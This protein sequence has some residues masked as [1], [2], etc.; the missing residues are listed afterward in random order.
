M[1]EPSEGLQALL[2]A[3][4]ELLRDIL[5]VLHLIRALASA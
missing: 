3:F 1:S 4:L 5:A 2:E